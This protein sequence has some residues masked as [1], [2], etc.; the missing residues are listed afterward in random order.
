[1]S[2]ENITITAKDGYQLGASLREP[3][4]EI[5]GVIQIN[6]GTGIPKEFYKHFATYLT[7]LGYVTITFDYRGIGSSKPK[8]LKGFKA[9]N[10]E[11]A[12]LDI[13]SILDWS[14]KKY[15]SLE[16]IV[17]GHSMGGQ[18]IGL[19]NNNEK[20]DKVF[21]IASGTGYW[22]DM[23]K[24]LTK[25]LMPFLWYFYMP[26]NTLI[27][28]Y[29]NAKKINQGENLP[30]GVALQWRKWCL[31]KDYWENEFGKTINDSSFSKLTAP[32]KSL[33]FMD[34]NLI[35]QKANKKLLSYYNN[36]IINEVKITPKSVSLNKI[37]HF[38]YF[39]RKSEKLWGNLI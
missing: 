6:S 14:I 3:K 35:S 1:M 18:L 31:N 26:L 7:K 15:P 23:P 24:G 34:D 5:K 20:I 27:Y 32:I 12:T 13:S 30:K 25:M 21:I 2:K 28:G 38:G 29:S 36:S 17:I 9:T 4:N 22:K 39:S 16:K 19:M 11:W 37:G 10:L 8:S 33:V